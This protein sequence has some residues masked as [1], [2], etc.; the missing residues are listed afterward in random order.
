[1]KVGVL[2][3]S[4]ALLTT[5]MGADTCLAPKNPVK[6]SVVCGRVTAQNGEFVPNIELQLVRRD[7]T[8][9]TVQTDSAGDFMFGAIPKGDYDL[10]TKA[11]GWHLFWPVTVTSTKAQ[12]KCSQPLEVR[13]SIRSCG[14]GI[15]KSGYHPRF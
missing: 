6:A 13:V 3:V 11:K 4:M 15:S 14:Q 12:S 7:E 9:A 1:M 8:V 5:P 2:F 10:T